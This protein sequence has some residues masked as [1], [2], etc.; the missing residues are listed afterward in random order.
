MQ[1]YFRVRERQ[2]LLKIRKSASAVRP[3]PNVKLDEDLHLVSMALFYFCPWWKE[4]GRVN[5]SF[6]EHQ[7]ANQNLHCGLQTPFT[8][9][10][11]SKLM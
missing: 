4:R 3:E 1:T 11:A 7:F 8:R 6:S 5:Y 10:C 9:S 2:N